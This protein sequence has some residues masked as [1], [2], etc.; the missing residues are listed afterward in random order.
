[1]KND[2]IKAYDAKG[3]RAS[4]KFADE[5]VVESGIDSVKLIGEKYAEQLQYGRR[6]GK[7]PPIEAIKQWI[8]D[9]GIVSNIKN[10]ANNSSLAFLIA[11]KIG[12]QGW[13]RQGYG[14]V[15][16]IDEVITKNR[17]QD[18]INKVGAELTLTFVSTLEREFENIK[19]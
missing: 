15:N 14:G 10:D 3:M 16:L 12:Q 9:K 17:I 18:I 4:G 19:V 5:L 2:L 8:K 11:R 7:R 13:N 6:A 1:L